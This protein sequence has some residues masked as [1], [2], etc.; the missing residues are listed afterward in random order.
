MIPFVQ[1]PG[2]AKGSA[3][4]T[5]RPAARAPAPAPVRPSAESWRT[6]AFLQIERLPGTR[7]VRISASD[8]APVEIDIG[9]VAMPIQLARVAFE[10]ARQRELFG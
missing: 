4:T 9:D 5:K 10:A 8:T 1:N 2:M 6:V 7:L 3:Q